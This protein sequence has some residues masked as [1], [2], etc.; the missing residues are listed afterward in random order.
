MLA[1]LF[2]GHGSEGL[3][4]AQ[5]ASDYMKGY[6]SQRS[7]EFELNPEDSLSK[8]FLECDESLQKAADVDCSLSGTT[9]LVVYIRGNSISCASVGDSRAIIGCTV[10]DGS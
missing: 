5:F 7:A 10:R 3:A 6:F 9:A 2:D 4:C 1:A 8:M